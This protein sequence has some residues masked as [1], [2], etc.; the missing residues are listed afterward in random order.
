[1]EQYR[2]GHYTGERALFR[3]SDASIERCLFDDGESPLKESRNLRIT[4]SSFGWKY[5][6]WYGKGHQVS[7]CLFQESARSGIWYTENSSFTGCDFVAPKLFRRCR[8]IAI[9][10][11]KFENAAETL[12]S[13]QN[14]SLKSVRLKGDYVLKDC[15]DVSLENVV[16][17]GNYALDGAKNV[18]I[19]HCI[20]NTKDAFWNCENVV[21]EDSIINGE[22]FAWNSRNVTLIACRVASNQGFCYMENVKLVRCALQGTDLCFEYC[23]GIDAD[24]VD[25][26]ISVKNPTSGIIRARAIGEVILDENRRPG[27]DCQI[28]VGLDA[29]ERHG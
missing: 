17:D 12:W 26:I 11:S 28:L 6:L 4:H 10:E 16:I 8:G 21:I 3:V 25:D 2:D 15:E 24:I 29:E 27:A 13:C 23:S 19:K 7:G 1:M 18:R 5:P 22:Y 14:V 20:L 9:A